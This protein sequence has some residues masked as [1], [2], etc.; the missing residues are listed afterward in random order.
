MKWRVI[1]SL[2]FEVE[3][4]TKHLATQQGVL[5]LNRLDDE[6]TLKLVDFTEPVD[7]VPLDDN[8]DPIL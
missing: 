7:V 2:E 6:A 3:A 5:K 4:P 8:G 1:Y